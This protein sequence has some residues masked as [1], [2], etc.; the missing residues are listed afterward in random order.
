MP[1]GKRFVIVFVVDGLRPDAITAEDTPT[2]FRLRTEGVDFT[3]GHAVFPTVTRVNAAA[4]GTGMQPGT[5]GIL[6]NQ[7][8]APAVDPHRAFDTGDYRNLLALDRATGGRL[9]LVP[10]LAERLAA[11][12]LRLA[13]VSSGSTGSALLTNPR[14][15]AGVGVLINGYFDPGRVVA[16]PAN[17]SEAVLAQFRPAPAQTGGDPYDATVTWT[18]RGLPHDVGPD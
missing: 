2:L 1:T 6:G 7:L 15:V 5:S 16:W 3:R 9:V 11:R 12:G 18:P 8:H 17:V 14:A 13:S 10:T 4:L